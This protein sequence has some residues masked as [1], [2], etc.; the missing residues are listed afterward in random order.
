MDTMGACHARNVKSVVDQHARARTA[1][2]VDASRHQTHQWA[3]VQIALTNLNEM[4]AFD[5]CG[6]HTTHEGL[7][8]RRA[9]PSAIG[10]QAEDWRQSGKVE[11]WKHVLL[12]HLFVA[13]QREGGSLG[14]TGEEKGNQLR[15]PGGEI[16]DAESRYRT[17]NE[18]VLDDRVDERHRFGKVVPIPERRP[19][20]HEQRDAELE[21]ERDDEQPFHDR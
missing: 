19:R 2:R 17:A 14:V 4:H 15:E 10:D 7:F 1:N 8:P 21:E 6:T 13:S 16:D 3:A 12:F 5:C 18:V 20:N 11:K 9:M